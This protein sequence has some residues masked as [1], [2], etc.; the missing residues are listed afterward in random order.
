MKI[1]EG[2]LRIPVA[3]ISVRFIGYAYVKYLRGRTWTIWTGENERVH[4]GYP[5]GTRGF[6]QGEGHGGSRPDHGCRDEGVSRKHRWKNEKIQT[7]TK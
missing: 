3:G 4:Q 1:H 7:E 2:L 6:H 5:E